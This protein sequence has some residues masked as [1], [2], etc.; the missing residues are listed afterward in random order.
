MKAISNEA[1]YDPCIKHTNKLHNVYVILTGI[2]SA[3]WREPD[4]ALL[5][6]QEQQSP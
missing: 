6:N 4:F 1:F 3:L 2:S 5:V